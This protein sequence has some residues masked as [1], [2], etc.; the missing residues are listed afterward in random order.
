MRYLQKVHIESA[1]RRGKEVEQFIEGFHHN[2]RKAIS[3]LTIRKQESGYV[4]MHH[5]QY[6]EGSKD[7]CDIYEYEYIDLP[8]YN[9]EPEHHVFSRLDQ[10]LSAAE[11]IGAVCTKWV[12][13]GMV[14]D[15]YRDY[16]VEHT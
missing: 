9:Y 6:D 5:K 10:A 4:L 14:Q 15:E 13:H 8:E 2:D 1:M 7:Y 3:W 12:G 16:K 11:N